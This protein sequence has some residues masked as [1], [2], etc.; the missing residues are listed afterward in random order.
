M[1]DVKA[2]ITMDDLDKI[3]VR[4]GTIASVEDMPNSNKLVKLIVDFGDFKRQI[5]VGMKGERDNPKEIEGQ[6]ALFVVN[7][8]PRKM[9]GEMSEGMLFDIGYESGIIPVLAQPEKPVPN[10]TK[11]G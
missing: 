5:L 9:A 1:N 8:A 6:Q 10:G 2:N 3:D 4:V 11:V 7:L